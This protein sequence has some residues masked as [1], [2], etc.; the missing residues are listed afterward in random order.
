MAKMCC[1]AALSQPLH[2]IVFPGKMYYSNRDLIEIEYR[3]LKTKQGF[4]PPDNSAFRTEDVLKKYFPFFFRF[5]Y[6]K[7]P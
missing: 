3:R 1:S 2:K 6:F 5:K 7:P 4:Y